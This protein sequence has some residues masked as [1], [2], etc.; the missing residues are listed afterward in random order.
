M[1]QRAVLPV[2]PIHKYCA[3]YNLHFSEQHGMNAAILPK[4]SCTMLGIEGQEDN[5]VSEKL[6]S[7]EGEKPTARYERIR[8][9]SALRLS[10]MNGL[11]CVYSV[12]RCSACY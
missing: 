11:W 9:L 4:V 10:V 5:R 3:V 6:T 1:A 12:I 8:A 2:V 7:V